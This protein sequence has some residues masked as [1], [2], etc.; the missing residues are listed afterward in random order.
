MGNI[1]VEK[2]LNITIYILTALTAHTSL[3]PFKKSCCTPDKRARCFHF[4]LHDLGIAKSNYCGT[5]E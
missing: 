1:L 3:L 2:Y 4:C 5:D